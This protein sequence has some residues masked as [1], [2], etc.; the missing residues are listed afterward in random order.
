MA[1]P[2]VE[3]GGIRLDVLVAR[4]D[5]VRVEDELVGREEQAA[6][7]ALDALSAGGVV[8]GEVSELEHW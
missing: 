2:G 6:I 3:V 8:P 7:S 1:S 5:A 4:A